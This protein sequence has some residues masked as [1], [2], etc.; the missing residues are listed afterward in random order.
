M[1]RLR[2]TRP[3]RPGAP[4]PPHPSSPLSNKIPRN[5]NHS[6]APPSSRSHHH[7]PV[8]RP[9]AGLMP[10]PTVARGHTTALREHAS[11]GRTRAAPSASVQTPTASPSTTLPAPLPYRPF[12]PPQLAALPTVAPSAT[13]VVVLVVR[14]RAGRSDSVPREEAPTSWPRLATRCGRLGPE[15]G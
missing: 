2:R 6:T 12:S 5:Q 14:R 8:S 3:S 7:K 11:R 13:I 4:T 10:R 1:N 15:G 9:A